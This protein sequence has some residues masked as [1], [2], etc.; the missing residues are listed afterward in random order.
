MRYLLAFV[1]GVVLDRVF[2]WTQHWLWERKVR[3]EFSQ[4]LDTPEAM[5]DRLRKDFQ[6]G[7]RDR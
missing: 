5:I 6:K 1:A 2:F 7:R 4:H 3:R